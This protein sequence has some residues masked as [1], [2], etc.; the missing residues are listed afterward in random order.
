ML[1]F[2]SENNHQRKIPQI[3]FTKAGYVLLYFKI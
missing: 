3:I 1:F 2:Y